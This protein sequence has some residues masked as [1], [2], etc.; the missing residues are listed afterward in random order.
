[1]SPSE[2]E[3]RVELAYRA[4]VMLRTVL[5]VIEYNSNRVV[6]WNIE[7]LSG[8]ELD[9]VTPKAEWRRYALTQSTE[10]TDSMRVP[11]RL[12]FLLRET[13]ASQQSRLS[14]PLPPQQELKLLATVE[15]FM[16]AWYGMRKFLTT[17]VPFPLIQMTRTLVL[18][19]VF[20]L[21]LIFLKEDPGHL[22][23]EHCAIIFLL[24]YG[25]VGLELVS[26]ELDDPFGT[27][28]NDF[29]CVAYAHVVFED[30]YLMIYDTDGAEYA[31]RVR[32]RMHSVKQSYNNRSVSER[33]QLL[34]LHE[35]CSV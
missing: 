27:D 22:L 32:H 19:Y 5:S 10:R 20:T 33:A 4:M 3:W 2:K 24:T 29:D 26:I 14:R 23:F 15:G 17:P 30:T 12:C 9:Y 31:D 1:M 16:D 35:E 8:Y 11:V 13:I 18:I 6:A 34:S 28:A 21:P 7:E 25:F